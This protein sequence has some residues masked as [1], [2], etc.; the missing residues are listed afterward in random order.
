MN[1]KHTKPYGAVYDGVKDSAFSS[2]I[3][4]LVDCLRLSVTHKAFH[5]S[6]DC[7][8]TLR[9]EQIHNFILANAMDTS[10]RRSN[11]HLRSFNILGNFCWEHELYQF[12]NDDY[13]L[14]WSVYQMSQNQRSSITIFRAL[15]N[16]VF[17]RSFHEL[18]FFSLAKEL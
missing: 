18:V 9:F 2:S 14:T 12:I 5:F 16:V 7:I 13:V 4:I 10:L 6:I 17:F 11:T 1:L 8:R 15:Y 3:M